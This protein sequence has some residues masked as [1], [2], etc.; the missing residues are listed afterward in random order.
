MWSRNLFR[1][2][3]LFIQNGLWNEDVQ[4]YLALTVLECP[5]FKTSSTPPPNRSVY[6][7]SLDQSFNDVVCMDHM[8]LEYLTLCHATDVATRF[9][10]T[11]VVTSTNLI[12]AIFAFELLRVSQ[13]WPPDVIHA[14]GAFQTDLFKPLLKR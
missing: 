8:V 6:I 11:H 5:N 13:F 12:E 7:S 9:S 3:T 4:Q 14:D 2:G 10:A 1:K